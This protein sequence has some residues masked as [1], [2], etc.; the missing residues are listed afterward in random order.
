M[1]TRRA[2]L[3]S[4]AGLGAMALL[5]RRAFAAGP[6]LLRIG[7]ILPAGGPEAA[8][9]GGLLGAEEG[10]RTAELLGARLEL[11]VRTVS[12]PQA[13]A[14]EATK[15]AGSGVLAL[16][17]SLDGPSRTAVS[18]AAERLGVPLLT[19]LTLDDEPLRRQVF[20][21]AASP[22]ERQEAL[23]RW[24]AGRKEPAPEGAHA[25]D[26][27]PAL[28]RYGAD[29][30][31]QRFRERFGAAMDSLAWASWMAV[32]VATELALRNPSAGRAELAHRLETFRFDGHKGRRLAFRREDH[33]LEQPLYIVA[34]PKVLGEVSAEDEA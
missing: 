6:R 31:N 33:R 9:R 20:H 5:G 1:L 13:A 19:A 22:R 8:A 26:W 28:T 25:V 27:H 14:R 3:R 32:M 15:L 23:A 30:L 7:Q 34:G 11:V 21:V 29:Q 17:G 18:E 16:V 2:F 10:G 24:H 12:G 4:A